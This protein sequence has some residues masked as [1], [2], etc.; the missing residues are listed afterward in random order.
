ML[1]APAW[2]TIVVVVVLTTFALLTV[3]MMLL[4][5][6]RELAQS[7][8]T[9][10]DDL[11]PRLEALRAQAEVTRTELASVQE[12]GDELADQRDR[13]RRAGVRDGGGQLD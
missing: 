10:R 4:T 3:V 2:I 1:S 13:R 7:I 12:A 6:L 5:H 8:S 9:I 11:Q